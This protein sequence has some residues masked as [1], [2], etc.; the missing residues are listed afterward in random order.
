MTF[1][2]FLYVHTQEF[3]H[4]WMEVCALVTS[5]SFCH[6]NI[7]KKKN[8]FVTLALSLVLFYGHCLGYLN[9]KLACRLTSPE[10]KLY[11]Q[12]HM[13]SVGQRTILQVLQD[14]DNQDDVQCTFCAS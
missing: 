5:I 14:F 12:F 2:D 13:Q 7:K 4:L 10:C 8:S 9:A 11:P 1:C 6:F 3:N